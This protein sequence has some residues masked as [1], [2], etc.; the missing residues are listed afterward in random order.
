MAPSANKNIKF[1][2]D[3]RKAIQAVLWLLKRNNGSMDKLKLVKLFFLADREHLPRYGRPIIG[4]NYY[5]MDYG[6]VSSE[7]LNLLDK[8]DPEISAL[9]FNVS[10]SHQVSTDGCPDERWLS[11]S[12][13]DVLDDIYERYGHMDPFQ[14]SDLTHKLEAYR[15]NEPPKGGRK[16]LPYED[17]FLDLD[18]KAQEMLRIILDEQEAWADFR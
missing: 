16:E 1:Q 13:L 17:F 11:K 3:R 14:I 10:V 12:D 6:P 15:K 5:A 2:F 9:P 4:G 7:L 18:E 8:E